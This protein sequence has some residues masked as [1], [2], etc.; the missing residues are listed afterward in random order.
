MADNNPGFYGVVEQAV[1]PQPLFKVNEN[2]PLKGI[3]NG[4][5]DYGYGNRYKEPTDTNPDR[6]KGPGF[7]G[8]I[9]RPNDPNISGELGVSN[10]TQGEHPSMVPGLT[11]SELDTMLATPEG[12]PIPNSV[13]DKADSY[14]AFRQL[15]GQSPWAGVNDKQELTP[16]NNETIVSQELAH[17]ND[18]QRGGI[19]ASNP[20]PTV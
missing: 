2:P 14:A 12:K 1:N 3:Q 11:P 8:E 18:P 9:R 6:P 5:P 7:Y 19:N 20:A 10:R 17:P 4:M 15:N 13:Y 16:T